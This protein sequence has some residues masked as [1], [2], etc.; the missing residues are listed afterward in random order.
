MEKPGQSGF[1]D[2]RDDLLLVLGWSVRLRSTLSLS[3][4][5]YPTKTG[6]EWET[7]RFIDWQRVRF[8]S[9]VLLFLSTFTSFFLSASPQHHYLVLASLFSLPRSVSPYV[10]FSLHPSSA[11]REKSQLWCVPS[12]SIW[13]RCC[14]LFCVG[15][16]T[17]GCPQL[18]HTVLSE[19]PPSLHSDTIHTLMNIR[20]W[21][22]W[23]K[24]SEIHC[25]IFWMDKIR[26]MK[27][28]GHFAAWFVGLSQVFLQKYLRRNKTQWHIVC[29]ALMWTWKTAQI[30]QFG[31]IWWEMFI[32]RSLTVDGLLFSSK[33][34]W[35]RKLNFPPI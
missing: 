27:K 18:W 16:V 17:A 33:I 26:R 29:R 14:Q 21:C 4:H 11:L 24:A 22:N 23:H 3:I 6:R 12:G 5:D 1:W 20:E 9:S 8:V 34:I 32:L 7:S 19:T 25:K 28:S 10:S 13:N 2:T 31:R 35:R 30:I 15:T